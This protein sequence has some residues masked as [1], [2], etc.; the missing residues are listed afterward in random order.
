MPRRAKYR[1]MSTGT[2]RSY[3]NVL[4][5]PG[6]S[7]LFADQL[8]DIEVELTYRELPVIAESCGG[9]PVAE[10]RGEQ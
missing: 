6:L 4:S 2:L 10:V 8:A 1:C 9:F 5:S 3:V 7:W